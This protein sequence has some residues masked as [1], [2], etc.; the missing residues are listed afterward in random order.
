MQHVVSATYSCFLFSRT[1]ILPVSKAL[2]ALHRI[3]Y[4][5]RDINAGNILQVKRTSGRK[6]GIVADLEFVK[7]AADL[8]ADHVPS[9]TTMFMAGEVLTRSWLFVIGEFPHQRFKHHTLHGSFTSA[10][11]PLPTARLTL[12]INNVCRH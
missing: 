12:F 3:G 2:R 1:L 5:H 11:S 8:D 7:Q 6:V 10:I 4:V 9:G